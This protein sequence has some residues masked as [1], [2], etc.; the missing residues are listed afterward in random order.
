MTLP[1]DINTLPAFKDWPE[2]SK[3]M[4]ALSANTPQPL[5]QI[6]PHANHKKPKSSTRPKK[7]CDFFNFNLLNLQSPLART[8]VQH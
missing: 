6:L 2:G 3:Q 7:G 1:Q 8:R 5:Q 4:V